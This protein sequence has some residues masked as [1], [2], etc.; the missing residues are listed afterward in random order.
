MQTGVAWRGFLQV[1]GHAKDP[2][3]PQ[4]LERLY[5]FAE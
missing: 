5:R 3:F 2:E 4:V 1:F